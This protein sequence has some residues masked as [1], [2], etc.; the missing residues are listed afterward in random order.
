MSA[1][2][3]VASIIRTERSADR[4]DLI[5]SLPIVLRHRDARSMSDVDVLMLRLMLM[6]CCNCSA[7]R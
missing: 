1:L 4:A 2:T 6:L 7:Y 5:V 3:S